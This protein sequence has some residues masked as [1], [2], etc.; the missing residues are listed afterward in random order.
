MFFIDWDDL[1]LNLPNPFVPAQFYIAN[2]DGAR[3]RGVEFEAHRRGRAKASTCSDAFGYTRATFK[4]GTISSGLDVTENRLPNTPSSP[5]RAGDAGVAAGHR[6]V[7]VYG[8]G[9][10]AS[11]GSVFL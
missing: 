4:D 10:M 1:Q 8:R 6:A 2:V 7:S 11:Y 5:S 3:S 9:E